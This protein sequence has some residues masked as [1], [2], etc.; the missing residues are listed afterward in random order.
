MQNNAESEIEEIVQPSE[1]EPSE[2]EETIQSSPRQSVHRSTRTKTIPKRFDEFNLNFSIVVNEPA[3]FE[4]TVS[5]NEWKD[6]MQKEYD[7]LIKNDT[8]RLVDPPI[9]IKPIGSKWVY[10]TKYKVDGSLDKYKARLVEWI[11]S[12]R[13]Y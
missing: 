13:R 7:A 6:E 9:G 10:K 11:C 12:K 1:I 3:T 8:W 5:C 4:E 2:S